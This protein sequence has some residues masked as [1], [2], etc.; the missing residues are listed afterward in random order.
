VPLAPRTLCVAVLCSSLVAFAAPAHAA[1]PTTIGTVTSQFNICGWG[2]T[3]ATNPA[4]PTIGQVVTAPADEQLLDSFGL[5]L[6]QQRDPLTDLPVGDPATITFRAYVYAWD[7]EKATGPALFES[8][9]QSFTTSPATQLVTVETG[10]VEVTPGSSYLLFFSVDEEL[11]AN[12]AGTQAC[13]M[14]AQN[15]YAGGAGMFLLDDVDPADWTV[16]PWRELPDMAFT[17][18]FST[19]AP[20][21]V[22][23]FD[24]FFAPVDNRDAGGNYILNQVKAGSAVPIK[25][26]LNG[27]QGLD[28]LASGSPSS[29]SITC[30]SQAEVDGIEQTVAAGASGL[31]YSAATDTYTYVWKTSRSW[32]ETCRQLVVRLDDGTTARANFTFSR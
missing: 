31:S 20:E 28:I 26:S 10:G 4:A 1:T 16:V 8:E 13:W 30:N 27:D 24:G 15:D 14:I 32:E 23:D 5:N 12:V 17:A 22:Y 21:P 29:Q 2:E 11:D 3:G 7:G 19:P 18:T 25:F 6:T 9:P